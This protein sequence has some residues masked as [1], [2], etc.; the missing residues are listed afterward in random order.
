[1][2]TCVYVLLYVWEDERENNLYSWLIS[3]LLPQASYL[4]L[5]TLICCYQEAWI[6]P[7][8]VLP[9]PLF[10][11]KHIITLVSS[12]GIKRM[13]RRNWNRNRKVVYAWL[14]WPRLQTWVVSD[15]VS[16]IVS[17]TNYVNLQYLWLLR[18]CV[19]NLTNIHFWIQRA[20]QIFLTFPSNERSVWKSKPREESPQSLS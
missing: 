9:Y 18:P 11:S 14:V 5:L 4:R 6:P 1:M 16:F 19:L 7:P 3:V 13:A 15:F 2:C 8:L 20:H 10:F 12:S 17:P